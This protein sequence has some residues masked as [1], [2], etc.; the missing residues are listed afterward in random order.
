MA[1]LQY[2][3][4]TSKKI[5]ANVE[6]SKNKLVSYFCLD[7]RSFNYYDEVKMSSKQN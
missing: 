3:E 1:D 5:E 6:E 2:D 7:K 4:T